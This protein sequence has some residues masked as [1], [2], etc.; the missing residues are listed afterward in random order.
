MDNRDIHDVHA[1]AKITLDN[2][3]V[4]CW[5]AVAAS[6]RATYQSGWRHWLRWNVLFGTNATM[7]KISPAWT[8]LVESSPF[9][10]QEACF[11]SFMAYL[12]QEI[13]VAPGS[14]ST[15]L[16]GTAFMLRVSNVDTSFIEKSQAI[17]MTRTGMFVA[18]RITAGKMVQ[19]TV[20]LPFTVDMIIAAITGHLDIS[21]CP[22]RATAT[23]I[24]LAYCCLLRVSEYIPTDADH[25]LLSESV[26][27]VVLSTDGEIFVPSH[28]IHGYSLVDVIEVVVTIRSAKND[29]LGEGHRFC[30]SKK[31]PDRVAGVAFDLAS[32]LYEWASRA[33][34]LKGD[35]FFSSRS[36][37]TG[38]RRGTVFQLK[39]DHI[40]NTLKAVATAFKMDST[41]FS[42]H[43]LRIGGA[44]ALAAAK[45]PDYIVQRIGRWKSL[46]FLKYIRLASKAFND[47][48]SLMCNANTLTA[49]EVC[50]ISSGCE[51]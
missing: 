27:F 25:F 33:R 40:N 41:R 6:S 31:K 50:K 22:G 2:A 14:V 44:S 23:A 28:D 39:A 48:I 16:A 43:S 26:V 15:Y 37:N 35:M 20:T 42:T 4:F 49:K 51:L 11:L 3:S 19:D 5:N 32:D 38:R 29:S 12:R 46:A 18:Y 9:S 1:F 8:D 36:G 47:A 13:G 17:K 30:F 45:V 24:V 7:T 10:Y 21:T 34:P